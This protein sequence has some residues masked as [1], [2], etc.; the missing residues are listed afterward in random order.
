MDRTFYCG[1]LTEEQI[2]TRQTVCGWVQTKRDMGGVI[3]IDL[4]EPERYQGLGPYAPARRGNLQPQDTN[5]HH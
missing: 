1:L 4:R 5:R 2:D 3:F